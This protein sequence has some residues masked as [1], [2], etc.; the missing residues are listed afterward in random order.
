MESSLW[1]SIS[2][3]HQQ[4]CDQFLQDHFSTENN[5]IYLQRFHFRAPST[6]KKG[7]DGEYEHH[8]PW[9]LISYLRYRYRNDIWGKYCRMCPLGSGTEASGCRGQRELRVPWGQSLF[10]GSEMYWKGNCNAHCVMQVGV[11]SFQRAE[12]LWLSGACT[13][14]LQ[15]SLNPRWQCSQGNR[16]LS[17][18]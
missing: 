18:K 12:E 14:T 3:L 11:C 17:T 7:T 6:L 16:W 13:D 5:Y 8:H 1:S 9:A 10:L 2:N 4:I 15:I